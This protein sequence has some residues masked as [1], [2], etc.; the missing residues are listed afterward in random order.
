MASG[1]T[2][3][4]VSAETMQSIADGTLCRS[5]SPLP[6]PVGVS[7]LSPVLTPQA[8]SVYVYCEVWSHADRRAFWR[9]FLSRLLEHREQATRVIA[10]LTDAFGQGDRD[11]DFATAWQDLANGL[12]SV[13]ELSTKILVVCGIPFFMVWHPRREEYRAELLDLGL[14]MTRDFVKGYETAYDEGGVPQCTGRLLADLLVLLF[15]ALATKG[16]GKLVQATKISKLKALIPDTVR[17]K[18]ARKQRGVGQ[19]KSQ[20]PLFPDLTDEELDAA[21]EA[22]ESARVTGGRT[23]PRIGGHAVPRTRRPRLDLGDLPRRPGE[24]ARAALARVQGVIGKKISDVPPLKLAWEKAR[25]RILKDNTLEA[26]N[27]SKLYDATRNQ[28][29]KEV[30][31]DP[32]AAKYLRDAGFE[33]PP[34]AEQA[35][36]LAG[37]RPEVPVEEIRISLDHIREKAIGDNWR[38]ALD[39]DNLELTFQNPNAYRE[40]VQMRHPELRP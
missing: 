27:Y 23:R 10:W 36:K 2:P 8:A 38:H 21:F 40:V 15:E 7:F 30:R 39:A 14:A 6:G 29:W 19:P 5:Q 22:M 3:G 20:S 24:G 18:L 34:R 9:G 25:A 35:A 28:F 26:S 17:G 31:A 4:P 33:F 11:G 1:R 16:A 12:G 13:V 37:V 32:A